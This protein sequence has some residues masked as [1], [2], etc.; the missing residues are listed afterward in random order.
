M[1]TKLSQREIRILKIGVVCAIAILV[2]TFGTK[3]LDHWGQV[4]KSLSQTKA[5]LNDISAG[6]AKQSGLLTI[7]PVFEMPRPEEEQKFL[8]RDKFR[9]QLKKAGIKNEP[10]QVLPA[11]KRSQVGYKLL[12]LKC[13]AKCKFGQMLDLLVNLKENPY[14]VAIEEM[15]IECDPKKPPDKRSEIELD[16][17]VSTFVK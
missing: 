5:K 13:K 9:E 8:F 3:W 14:F 1:K 11:A 4:R 15:R 17:T 7:V 16:L 6:Q 10:L 12:R 2:L